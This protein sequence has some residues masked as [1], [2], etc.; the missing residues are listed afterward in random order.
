MNEELKPKRYKFTSPTWCG[1]RLSADCDED[2]DGEYVRLEDVQP[3]IDAWN[4]RA[5]PTSEPVAP[6]LTDLKRYF[7]SEFGVEPFSKVQHK[8]MPGVPTYFLADDV[9]RLLAA[10]P[11]APVSALTDERALLQRFVDY[12]SKPAGMTLETAMNKDRLG[13]FME[14]VEAREKEL[15]ASARALLA[16]SPKAALVPSQPTLSPQTESAL[17]SLA[18][19]GQAMERGG[20]LVDGKAAENLMDAGFEGGLL[21][22]VQTVLDE[23]MK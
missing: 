22:P 6:E 5:A 13:E 23:R 9:E 7:N 15:V 11:V 16:A 18:D 19:Q 1:G 12:H 14:S 8:N 2:P 20:H 21:R 4:R 3:A 17:Q 10:S